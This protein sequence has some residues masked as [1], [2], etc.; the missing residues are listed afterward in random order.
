M[1][2]YLRQLYLNQ[3][4]NQVLKGGSGKGGRGGRGRRGGR[5]GRGI[6]RRVVRG[7]A[8]GAGPEGYCNTLAGKIVKAWDSEMMQEV[9]KPNIVKLLLKTEF[10]SDNSLLSV[11]NTT[12]RHKCQEFFADE[13]NQPAWAEKAVEELIKYKEALPVAAAGA[14]AGAVAGAA[15]VATAVAAPQLPLR[16]PQHSP[17]FC[18]RYRF[19]NI[20]PLHTNKCAATTIDCLQDD[21]IN[22]LLIPCVRTDNGKIC[23]DTPTAGDFDVDLEDILDHLD[24]PG[25]VGGLLPGGCYL[26]QPNDVATTDEYLYRLCYHIRRIEDYRRNFN[27][28]LQRRLCFLTGLRRDQVTCGLADR[29]DAGGQGMPTGF[30]IWDQVNNSGRA[31]KDG[32]HYHFYGGY[33]WGSVAGRKEVQTENNFNYH[34]K[35]GPQHHHRQR[36]YVEDGGDDYF[37]LPAPAVDHGQP[38]RL[39]HD[40]FVSVL[41]K[42]LVDIYNLLISGLPPGTPGTQSAPVAGRGLS[43]RLLREHTLM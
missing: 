29:R 6:A 7:D 22:Q 42:V 12:I 10:T 1:N 36:R 37:A 8:G 13:G 24:Q 19:Y 26:A 15:A 32:N 5:G 3:L 14:V 38:N 23:N 39:T 28:I 35:Y 25:M 27:N 20:Q 41:F 16:C 21:P 4:Q 31:D 43:G 34:Y 33:G 40:Q 17:R 2:M 18:G 11:D 30:F 9:I